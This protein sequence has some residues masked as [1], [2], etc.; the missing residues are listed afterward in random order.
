[1][2]DVPALKRHAA[3]RWPE[4]LSKF[5]GIPRELLDG[6][7]HAC[8]KCG[9]GDRFRLIDADA[10]A[11]HCNQCFTSGNGDGIAAMQ[12]YAGLDFQAACRNVQEYLGLS[13]GHSA[14]AP[15]TAPRIVKTYDYRDEEDNLLFQVVRYE[16]GYDGRSKDFRQR[17][18]KSDGGFEW[19]LKGTRRV[20][21]RLPQLLAAPSDA[22][23]VIPE[24]EKDV[25]NLVALGLTA[26]CNSGG[27]GKWDPAF[28]QNLAGRK[29]AILPDKDRPGRDHA[30]KVARSLQGIA[31]SVKVLELP[32]D[33]KDVS[34]WLSTGGD[35]EQLFALI[36][37]APEWAPTD[38]SSEPTAEPD[39][40][41]ATFEFPSISCQEL[42]DATYDLQYL[43][44]DILVANQ[45]CI[46][47]GGKKTLKTSL[48]I[49]AGISLATGGYFLGCLKV[50]RPC[51]VGI[52]TG[53]S[54]LATIQETA[55][56]IAQAAGH[57]L[58]NV[59]GLVFTD[60]LPQFTSPEH[61]DGLRR[62]I[63][64]NAL[65]I[66]VIDPAY[67][68]LGDADHGNLFAMGQRLQGISQL[69]QEARVTLILAHHNRKNGKADPY[70]EPELEDIAW[71]GFQE[72]ARQWILVGRRE[73][74]EPGTGDH[75]LWLSAGGSA[76]HSSLWAV[77]ISEGTRQ[78]PNGRF[79]QVEMKRADEA[80][81]ESTARQQAQKYQRTAERD[82]ATLD[83]DRP[84]LVQAMVRFKTPQTR[85]DLR[86][87]TFAGKRFTAA[88]ASLCDDGTFQPT[89]LVKDNG[90]TYEAWQLRPNADDTQT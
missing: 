28:N 22:T 4:I 80:R 33:G 30:Q 50:T 7:H 17:R 34:D 21:Y 35:E 64:H 20:P 84:K 52:M 12:H 37:A 45:P 82:A 79:W 81:R 14:N 38:D 1:V 27:A 88:F 76:G 60:Q 26:T 41:T 56:R 3:G 77:D 47:A 9:G 6:K 48:L 18:P 59:P 57:Q 49:D 25:D 42:D 32:G 72:F 63:A 69:C 8:P 40:P 13:N 86:D 2:I 31:A 19:S 74:Y 10:G 62:W 67:L 65:E 58:R 46:L 16:P 44:T 43:V 11:L 83:A 75:R 66:L 78:T 70:S 24:G 51:R 73:R 54:G 90:H 89:T 5:A 61:M 15:S 85:T 55:R 87:R 71:S 39:E 68:C 29:I 23:V 36:D 53:E